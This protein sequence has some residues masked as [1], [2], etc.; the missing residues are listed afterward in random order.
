MKLVPLSLP[1]RATVLAALGA[2]ASL[3]CGATPLG[4]TEANYAKASS[5]PGAAVF[6]Q[7][8]ASCHGQRGEGLAQAPA[9]M[10]AGALPL[11]V[12]DPSTTSNPAFQDIAEQQRKQSLPP[13]AD[14]RGAFRTA[15]DLFKYV[16][17]E[18]PR[19]LSKRGSLS[20]EDYWAVVNFILAGHG[21]ALPAG[22]VTPANADSVL[23]KPA[24]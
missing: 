17:R 16:S 23:I 8:C 13:G 10:G 1:T 6:E 3:G 18:M 11:Y 14:A 15:S 24:E 12:R 7:N 2:L 19:P 21:S 5:L 4:A 20:P 22:G 9:V